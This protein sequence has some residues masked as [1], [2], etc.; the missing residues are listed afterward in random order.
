MKEGIKYLSVRMPVELHSRLRE[1]AAIQRRSINEQLVKILEENTIERE[2]REPATPPGKGM[3]R[4]RPQVEERRA[5]D[6]S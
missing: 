5:A 3:R 6:V 1:I 2:R 4:R